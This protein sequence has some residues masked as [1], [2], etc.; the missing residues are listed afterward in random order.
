MVGAPPSFVNEPVVRSAFVES[1]ERRRS[2]PV[3]G[4]G[5]RRGR[6]DEQNEIELPVTL[7]R[8]TEPIELGLLA[9]R[10]RPAEG[11]HLMNASTASIGSS[12][13]ET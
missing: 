5:H 6:E 1:R 4:R 3:A 13:A 7:E 9:W 2:L 10:R 11:R 12:C 8:R